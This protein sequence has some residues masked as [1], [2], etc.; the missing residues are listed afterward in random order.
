[1]ALPTMYSQDHLSALFKSG[2]T[3]SLPF[4]TIYIT[5]TLK[6][7]ENYKYVNGNNAIIRK[8]ASFPADGRPMLSVRGVAYHLEKLNIQGDGLSDISPCISV[9]TDRLPTDTQANAAIQGTWEQVN[10]TQSSKGWELGA[11]TTIVNS[12]GI[13]ASEQLFHQCQVAVCGIG[14]QAN[15][16]NTLNHNWLQPLFVAVDVGIYAKGAGCIHIMGG[17]ATFVGNWTGDIAT[18]GA[19]MVSETASSYSIT[20]FRMEGSSSGMLFKGLA[21]DAEIAFTAIANQSTG[22]VTYPNQ[23]DRVA[24]YGSGNSNF[25]L[26]GNQSWDESLIKWFGSRP[27]G[28]ITSINN[29]SY[30]AGYYV[31]NSGASTVNFTTQNDAATTIIG[32]IT[33]FETNAWGTN[34]LA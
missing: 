34:A 13:S 28:R 26:I 24:Y 29:T 5:D 12:G 32:V 9:G 11:D 18:S 7:R 1:M 30:D 3:V 27:F 8:H 14:V 6:T 10:V 15:N 16:G 25:T 19:L 2:E 22:D 4:Q 17:T 21:T 20:A 23:A 31:D 33:S